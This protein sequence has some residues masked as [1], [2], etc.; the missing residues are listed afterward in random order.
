MIATQPI[1]CFAAAII[2][3]SEAADHT[4]TTRIRQLRTIKIGPAG[5]FIP[6]QLK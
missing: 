3:P 4:L 2:G 6:G 5:E 1:P